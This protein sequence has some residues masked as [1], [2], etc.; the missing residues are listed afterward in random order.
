MIMHIMRVWKGKTG[1]RVHMSLVERR[2]NSLVVWL[3]F[4]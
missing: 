3:K 1:S 2:R 4:M